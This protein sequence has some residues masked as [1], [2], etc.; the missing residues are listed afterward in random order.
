MYYLSLRNIIDML[1]FSNIVTFYFS[2]IT[3]FYWIKKI[4][5]YIIKNIIFYEIYLRIEKKT[6]YI[7][8]VREFYNFLLSQT[9]MFN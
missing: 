6:W 5:Y 7:K 3:I 1:L 9:I 4:Y 8:S 2:Y